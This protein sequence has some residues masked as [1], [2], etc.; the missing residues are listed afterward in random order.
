MKTC[1]YC[2][3]SILDAAI[4]CKHC[5]RD[6]TSGTSQVQLV[7]SRTS[8]VVWILAVIIGIFVLGLFA[9]ACFGTMP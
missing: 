3:E 2:A 1:P 4:V 9:Q 6:L 8:P 5:Q 7:P